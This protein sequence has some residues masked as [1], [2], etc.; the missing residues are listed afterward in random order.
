MGEDA[1]LLHQLSGLAGFGNTAAR[2]HD[3]LIGTG[4][5]AHSVRNDQYRFIGDQAGERG[6]NQRFVLNVQ[7][8]GCFIQQDDRCILEEGARD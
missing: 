4:D 3:H 1:V 8:G 5:R 7:R 6:L 2:E